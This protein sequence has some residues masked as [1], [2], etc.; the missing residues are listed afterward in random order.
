MSL[1]HCIYASAARHALDDAARRELLR[2]ARTNNERLGVTG[3]LLYVE[4]S[5]FQV[6]E[7]EPEVVDELFLRIAGDP[8]HGNVTEI[9]R[10]P[11]TRRAF[12]EWSMGYA[13]VSRADI[14]ATTGLN[15][16]FAGASCLR[17]IDGGRAKKLLHAF[18]CG[19]WRQPPVVLPQRLRSA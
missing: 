3:M 11:I 5:F 16:F 14:L 13:A 9:I 18:A 6:L 10:E 2:V 12:P 4:N 8:R 15:D 17:N 1:I 7:G 19:R